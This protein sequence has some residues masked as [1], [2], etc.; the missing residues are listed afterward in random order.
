MRRPFLALLCLA[1]SAPLARADGD[2][3]GPPPTPNTNPSLNPAAL[4]GPQPGMTALFGLGQLDGDLWLQ[5]STLLDFDLG[6][7][8]VGLA[9][10]LNL[11]VKAQDES[12]RDAKTYFRVLRRADYPAVSP[13]TL[14]YYAQM[15]RSVRYGHKRAPLYVQYGLLYGA[16]LGH[17]TVVDRYNNSL[18]QSRPHAGLALD[19][20]TRWGGF[21][22]LVGDLT[23]P[24]D[25]VAGGRAYVRPFGG[26]DRPISSRWAIGVSVLGDHGA[27]REMSRNADGK[28][29]VGKAAP[30]TVYG[31]DT[32]VEVF[33]N[34]VLQLVP[35]SDLNFQPAG[36]GWHTGVMGRFR[37]PVFGALKLWSRLEYRLL[38]P[39]YIPEYFDAAYDLQRYAYPVA[40]TGDLVPKAAAGTQLA[41]GGNDLRGSY[42]G[43]A[44]ADLLG[45]FQ[46]GAY[47]S[48]TPSIAKSGSLVVFATVPA[49]QKLKV[50]AYYLKKNFDGWNELATLDDRSA[51]TGQALYQ[52]FDAPLPTFLSALFQRRWQVDGETG[53]LHAANSWSV[54]FQTRLAF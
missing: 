34:D 16:T 45:L 37:F 21:E 6:D 23:N 17:G 22:S 4:L 1:L 19:V 9:L 42:Y 47:H 14:G 35:Y 41:A 52:L 53:T 5:G 10:P 15:L 39:G 44:T 46:L 40:A 33:S 24:A 31:I 51:L 29:L 26:A 18:D 36:N 7:I 11:L 3:F 13:D 43:E 25:S 38:Q 54:G 50:S 32:E 49:F 12:T 8:G 27:P 30:L 48:R 2:D 28:S 20:N